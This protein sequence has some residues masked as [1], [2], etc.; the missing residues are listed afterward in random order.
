[1]LVADPRR[2]DTVRGAENVPSF[3]IHDR[4]CE[5]A[6]AGPLVRVTATAYVRVEPSR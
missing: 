1:M 4:W 6:R 5:V 3:P 2:S